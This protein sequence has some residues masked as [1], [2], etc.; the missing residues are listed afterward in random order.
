MNISPIGALTTGNFITGGGQANNSFD[1]A[2]T[3]A[4]A[5]SFEAVLRDLQKK[6]KV[7]VNHV[8]N[9]AA[10]SQ[11]DKELKEACKGFEAMFLNM[12]YKEMRA[13]VPED[14]LFGES[15]AQKIF[16]DMHDEKLMENIADGG[17]LG[18][19]DMLYKQLSPQVNGRIDK[20]L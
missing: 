5:A 12:M 1:S 16:R 17:G 10:K 15:N 9:E 3:A 8:V 7:G 19:A 13:T 4:E 20:G 2:S 18:L 11:Q 14:T 6:A